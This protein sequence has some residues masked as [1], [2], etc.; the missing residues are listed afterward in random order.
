MLLTNS[1][2]STKQPQKSYFFEVVFLQRGVFF[3]QVKKNT[4]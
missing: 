2:F 4:S 1:L 3:I